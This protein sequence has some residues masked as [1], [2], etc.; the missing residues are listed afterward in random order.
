MRKYRSFIAGFTLICLIL[1]IQSCYSNRVIARQE[2]MQKP[3]D[4]IVTVYTVDT[5]YYF[6]E[7]GMG[8]V[9]D[10]T[11]IIGRLERGPLRSIHITRVAA[12]EVQKINVFKVTMAVAAIGCLAFSAIIAHGYAHMDQ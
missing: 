2:L 6:D 3:C 8:R 7:M 5:T 11:L 12:V 4:N 9:I 1:G 10:D